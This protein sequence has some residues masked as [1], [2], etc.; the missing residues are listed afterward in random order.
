MDF[1]YG[2]VQG[3]PTSSSSFSYAIHGK[4]KEA[5]MKLAKHGG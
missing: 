2:L 1:K 4:V 3:S 5:D